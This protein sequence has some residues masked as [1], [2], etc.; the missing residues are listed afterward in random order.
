[1]PENEANAAA[2]NARD[3]GRVH[4]GPD[5]RML[6]LD[7]ETPHCLDPENPPPD[8]SRKPHGRRGR[9]DCVET[10]LQTKAPPPEAGSGHHV[11]AVGETPEGLRR[12]FEGREGPS[13]AQGRL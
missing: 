9:G 5:S 13:H 10:R 4:H 6:P 11:G 8:A 2:G 3:S 7:P 12:R 1:M